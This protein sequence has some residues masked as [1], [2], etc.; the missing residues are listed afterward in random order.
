MKHARADASY[1]ILIKWVKLQHEKKPVSNLLS[2][3]SIGIEQTFMKFWIIYLQGKTVVEIM[4][5]AITDSS[6]VWCLDLCLINTFAK[7]TKAER[8]KH[9]IQA[10]TLLFIC[11]CGRTKFIMKIDMK[12]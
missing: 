7:S 2:I 6:N 5:V 8:C 4:S 1:I 12:I 11:Y 10:Y 3:Q 9:Y